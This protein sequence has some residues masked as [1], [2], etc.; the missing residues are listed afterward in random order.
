MMMV[1]YR[2]VWLRLLVAA[3]LCVVGVGRPL[4]QRSEQDA[5]MRASGPMH[6]SVSTRESE[7]TALRK[8]GADE[9]GDDEASLGE[10]EPDRVAADRGRV[11][12]GTSHRDGPS[13][14]ALERPCARG[15]PIV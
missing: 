11:D 5:A 3:L 1:P 9:S 8:R 6:V 10:A 12:V 15:P 7:L 13:C 14:I 4:A 2:A